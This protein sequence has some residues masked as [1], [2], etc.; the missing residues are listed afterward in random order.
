MIPIRVYYHLTQINHWEEVTD[1]IFSRIVSSG[2]YEHVE[3]I[4]IGVL[5][6]KEEAPKLE[7]LLKKYPKA[8]IRIHS[9][10]VEIFEY[11]TLRLLKEDADNLPLFYGLYLHSKSVTYPK[12]GIEGDAGR[13]PDGFKYDWY[14]QQ[15]MTYWLVE[16]WMKWYKALALKEIGYDIASVRV[17]P[18]RMSASTRTHGSGNFWSVNSEYFKTL[19][20]KGFEYSEWI[21]RFE[22]EMIAFSKMPIIYIMCNMFTQGFPFQTPFY[23]YMES[24]KNLDE[25]S[26]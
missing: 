26:I 25:Y 5:G 12:E 22:P 21:D 15:F 20:K 11:H 10:K 6:K 17:I 1:Y 3:G 18:A 9:E 7:D 14:W 13:T 16:N 23:E 8:S 4:Y 2:L 24:F 19:D